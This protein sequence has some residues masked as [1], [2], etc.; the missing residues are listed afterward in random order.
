MKRLFLIKFQNP[1]TSNF[2]PLTRE[3]FVPELEE[4]YEESKNIWYHCTAKE[5]MYVF[6]D[7]KLAE[8]MVECLKQDVKADI[9][10]VEFVEIESETDWN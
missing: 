3:D 7:K 4:K 6:E 5:L 2:I 9:K 1:N 10:I 8:Q